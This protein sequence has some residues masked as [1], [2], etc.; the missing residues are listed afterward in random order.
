MKKAKDEGRAKV[1]VIITRLINIGIKLVPEAL[2]A[3]TV[4]GPCRV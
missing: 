3:W 2:G 1:S 4:V